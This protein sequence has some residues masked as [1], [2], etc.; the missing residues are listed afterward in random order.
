MKKIPYVPPVTVVGLDGV[1]PPKVEPLWY[2][3]DFFCGRMSDASFVGTRP[4]M[5]ALFFVL[6]TH[7]ELSKQKDIAPTRGFWLLEDERAEAMKRATE[8]PVTPYPLFLALAF[9]PLC[10]AVKAME[11]YEGTAA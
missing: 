3:F 5:E 6:G 4:G 10:N 1:P 2:Q 7:K 11:P 9:E 8:T